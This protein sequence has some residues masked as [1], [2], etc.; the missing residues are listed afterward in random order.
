MTC[1]WPF[2]ERKKPVIDFGRQSKHDPT[3]MFNTDGKGRPLYGTA[4]MSSPAPVAYNNASGCSNFVHVLVDGGASDH[5][6]DNFLI[7]ELNRRLLD[8]TLASLRLARSSPLGG[9]CSTVPAK[10]FFRA[11]SPT[12]MATVISFESRS[13]MYPRLG[14]TSSR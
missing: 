10:E 11:S 9:C 13:Q 12:I 4:L 8:Y 7:P 6:F 5:Y 3:Y 14:A 1:P 2:A